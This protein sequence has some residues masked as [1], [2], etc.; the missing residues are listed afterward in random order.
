MNEGFNLDIDIRLDLF[1]LLE[2]GFTPQNHTWEPLVFP[3]LHGLPVQ[4]E[5]AVYLGAP[6]G[7]VRH[8]ERLQ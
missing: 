8:A 3:E 4:C 5:T 6:Q 1:D 7:R 2:A